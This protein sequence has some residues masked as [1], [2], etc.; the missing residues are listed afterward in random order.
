MAA[1]GKIA[2]KGA[3]G[4]RVGKVVNKFKVAKHFAL[5]INEADFTYRIREDRVAAESGSGRSAI[6]TSRNPA[7][8]STRLRNAHFAGELDAHTLN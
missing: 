7:S 3:I 2:G 8:A 1:K 4:V 6:G 5:E